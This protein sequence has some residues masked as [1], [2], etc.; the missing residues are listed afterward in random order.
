MV[1]YFKDR[2]IKSSCYSYGFCFWNNIITTKNKNLQEVKALKQIEYFYFSC[3]LMGC[4]KQC[5]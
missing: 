4:Q 5:I 1:L 2:Y 3:G